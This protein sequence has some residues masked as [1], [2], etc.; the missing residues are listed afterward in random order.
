MTEP[1]SV[2]HPELASG[3]TVEPTDDLRDAVARAIGDCFAV[4]L[5][6]NRMPHM[7]GDPRARLLPHQLR[8]LEDCAGAAADAAIAAYRQHPDGGG[9]FEPAAFEAGKHDGWIAGR[10]AAA[11]CQPATP[12]DPHNMGA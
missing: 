5:S 7:S 12:S 1:N 11:R 6:G 3:A 10:D 8:E 4:A 9:S 2:Q